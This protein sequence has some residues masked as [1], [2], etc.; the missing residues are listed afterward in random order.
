MLQKY[1]PFS[2]TFLIE[3]FLFLCVLSDRFFLIP[4][5][6]I[7]NLVHDKFNFVYVNFFC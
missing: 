4:K 2:F 5:F 1:H 7:L 3:Q 6:K